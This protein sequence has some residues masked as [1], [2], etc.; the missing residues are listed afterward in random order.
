MLEPEPELELE[1]ELELAWVLAWEWALALLV[2]QQELGR[3]SRPLLVLEWEPLP[4]QEPVVWL[5]PHCRRWDRRRE[6]LPVL[7]LELA[8]ASE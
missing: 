4:V 5:R 6:Q 2:W 1:L 8:Q 3:V 7:V